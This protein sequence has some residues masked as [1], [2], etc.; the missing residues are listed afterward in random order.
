MC[1]YNNNHHIIVKE[2]KTKGYSM[3][4]VHGIKGYRWFVLSWYGNGSSIGI[5]L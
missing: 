2:L 4:I 3:P 5:G 1:K